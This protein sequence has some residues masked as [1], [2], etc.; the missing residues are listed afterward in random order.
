[1]AGLLVDEELLEPEFEPELEPELLLEAAGV[2]V[3]APAA[4][5]AASLLPESLLLEAAPGGVELLWAARLSF[6]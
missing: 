2:E 6:R 5:L 3:L 1:L 4:G